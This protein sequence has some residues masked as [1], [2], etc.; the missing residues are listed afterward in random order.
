MKSEEFPLP[1]SWSELTWQQLCDCWQVKLRYGGN[2]DVARA[3]AFIALLKLKM[4]NEKLK[5]DEQTGEATYCLRNSANPSIRYSI[6]ARE[7]AY[8]AKQALPWFDFPYGDPGKP[9]VKD[10]KGKV[11][12][13]AVDPVR[14]YVSPMR[15]AMVLPVE[16]LIIENGK[17]KIEGEKRSWWKNGHWFQLPQA[18]CSNLTWEQ[19]RALQNITPQLFAESNT[20]EQTIE[21]QAQFLAHILTPRSFA[22]FDTTGGNIKIRPHY[23]YEYNSERAEKLVRWFQRQLKIENGKLKI[24]NCPLSTLFN[25]CFQVYQTALSY[26]A[27]VYPLLFE[28]GGKQDPLKDAL[29]GE[30]GTINT[31]MKYAGYASQQEV[32]DSNLPF[33]LD[34]LNTMSKEAKEIE[35]MN[36][37]IKKK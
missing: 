9:A 2:A 20:D 5:I 13:E 3:A 6:T 16:Q 25:M 33:I 23:V 28:G 10:D 11:V 36:A 24:I 4:E 34:I 8:Y 19:Y 21:L 22:L 15:D 29:T 31:V 30:V 14:G 37:K 1:H 17:L 12:K 35:K 18:A 32:Y 7:L 26:Y 27:A